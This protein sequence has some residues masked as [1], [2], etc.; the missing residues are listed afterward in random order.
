MNRNPLTVRWRDANYYRTDHCAAFERRV[1]AEG[2]P[3]RLR[4]DAASGSYFAGLFD[5]EGTLLLFKIPRREGW[6]RR[7]FVAQIAMRDDDAELIRSWQAALG[8]NIY[9][10]PGHAPTNPSVQWRMHKLADLAEVL[11]PLFDTYPLRSKKKLQ[12]LLWREIVLL[13]YAESLRGTVSTRWSPRAQKLF[14][15]N[16]ALMKRLRRYNSC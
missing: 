4:I 5:G 9:W 2:I 6:T 10:N 16:E 14:D 13:R 11:V 1:R 3:V 7:D 15:R 8:G 12:Y